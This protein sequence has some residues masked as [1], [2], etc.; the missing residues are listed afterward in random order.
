[1]D[2]RRRHPITGRPQ[3]AHVPVMGRPPRPGEATRPLMMVEP[4][5]HDHRPLMK[6]PPGAFDHNSFHAE[7]TRL[8][9][10]AV[11]VLTLVVLLARAAGT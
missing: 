8:L 1:M 5:R 6:A 7:L 9:W 3:P 4:S 2:D 11:F 10:C